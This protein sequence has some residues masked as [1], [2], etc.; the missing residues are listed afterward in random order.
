VVVW[1]AILYFSF[2]LINKFKK[3]TKLHIPKLKS[4]Q[5]RENPTKKKKKTQ[6]KTT[7]KKIHTVTPSLDLFDTPLSQRKL[8]KKIVKNPYKTNQKNHQ[9]HIKK[10]TK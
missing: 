9:A 4:K 1:G 3:R 2:F 6:K 8:T 5:K 7:K 10:I